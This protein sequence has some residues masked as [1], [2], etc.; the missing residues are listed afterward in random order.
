MLQALD[1][2]VFDDIV[3]NTDDPEVMSIARQHPRVT[4][5]KRSDEASRPEAH[6]TM[7]VDE[8]LDRLGNWDVWYIFSPPNPLRLPVDI[9]RFTRDF[10]PSSWDAA[11]GVI[12][13]PLWYW[14]G[15]VEDGAFKMRFPEAPAGDTQ[16]SPL[17]HVV[18]MGVMLVSGAAIA[19]RSVDSLWH[20]FMDNT[21]AIR[22]PSKYHGDI[23]VEEQWGDVEAKMQQHIL[24]HWSPTR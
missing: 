4:V 2:G 9:A 22:R 12:P 11:L 21:K 1:S 19:D 5:L 10:D 15:T 8:T 6:I 18:D 16:N 17:M 20:R 3:V 13:E 23:D 24:P 14:S 7:A